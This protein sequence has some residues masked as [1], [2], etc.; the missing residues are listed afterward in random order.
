MNERTQ[1][2]P[3]LR[4]LSPLLRLF[5]RL[6]LVLLREDVGGQGR[7]F[8]P[9][10]PQAEPP[11]VARWTRAQR[12]AY[13]SSTMTAFRKALQP[14]DGGA[15]RDGVLS[16]LAGYHGLTT[17]EALRRCIDWEDKSVQ[18]WE[19]APRDTPEG[20]ADFYNSVESWSFDLLW[21]SYLQSAGYG[22]PESVIAADRIGRPPTRGRLLDLGSGVGVTAQMFAELGFDVT[23][24]DVSKPLLEF[25]QWRLE[26][27]GVQATYVHLPPT[28]PHQGST[29]SQRST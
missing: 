18:E 20:L 23:L 27:R 25:A 14:R 15:E 26:Q 2:R 7:H 19:S 11:P 17:S 9:E 10:G 12:R 28:C 16:D 5:N 1:V 29:W 21:Y 8:D 6:A 24:A 4:K 13:D 22:Y 3:A